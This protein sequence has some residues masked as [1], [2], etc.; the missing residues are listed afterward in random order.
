MRER[1]E[2]EFVVV[3]FVDVVCVC[4]GWNLKKRLAKIIARLALKGARL[5]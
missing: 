4:G 2:K 1:E 3:V 5:R